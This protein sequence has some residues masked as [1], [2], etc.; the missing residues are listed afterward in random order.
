MHD[1]QGNQ[2]TLLFLDGRNSVDFSGFFD[3]IAD[4]FL[5]RA[6]TL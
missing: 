1:A 6:L 3:V 5:F 2:G 4:R